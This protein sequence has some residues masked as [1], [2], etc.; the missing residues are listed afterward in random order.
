MMKEVM[1]HK[2]IKMRNGR[3]IEQFKGTLYEKYK[4]FIDKITAINPDHRENTEYIVKVT[5]LMVRDAYLI[6]PA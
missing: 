2:V 3:K 4:D 5:A 6:D 1:G